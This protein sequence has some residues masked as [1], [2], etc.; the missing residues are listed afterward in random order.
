VGVAAAMLLLLRAS[1][2]WCVLGS[3]WAVVGGGAC[4]L[5][6][7]EVANTVQRCSS[8]AS[9]LF[10]PPGGRQG[11]LLHRRRLRHSTTTQPFM[12][13]SHRAPRTMEDALL[14]AKPALTQLVRVVHE[15]VELNIDWGWTPDREVSVSIP[16]HD[17]ILN[18]VEPG[19]QSEERGN[20]RWSLDNETRVTSGK[21]DVYL[22][23]TILLGRHRNPLSQHLVLQH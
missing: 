10:L 18:R 22:C 11:V 3:C 17:W 4:C 19:Q 6:K 2:C 13:N 15:R 23:C 7:N 16:T 12:P 14:A 9:P 1:Q 20:V 8:V 21:W 5:R